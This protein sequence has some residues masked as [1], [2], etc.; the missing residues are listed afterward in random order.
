MHIANILA[1]RMQTGMILAR[2]QDSVLTEH[3]RHDK[4]TVVKLCDI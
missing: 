2:K 3:M 1:S 4:V